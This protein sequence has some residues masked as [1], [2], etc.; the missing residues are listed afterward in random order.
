MG[1]GPQAAMITGIVKALLAQLVHYYPN[2]DDLLAQMNYRFYDIM[3]SSSL[4]I[5]ITAF[6]IVINT[7]TG[8]GIYAN[9]G[10]PNP[11]IIRTQNS[12]VEELLSKPGSALGLA[13]EMLYQI[14]R[15][16]L[17]NGDMMFMFTDGLIELMNEK[18]VQF[19]AEEL[20][21]AIQNNSNL[22]PKAFVEAILSSADAF[23]G[24]L[25]TEDDVTLLVF[26]YNQMGAD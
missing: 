14:G 1:H 21:R 8:K 18:R 11:F 12:Y 13:P 23:A 26:R 4:P 24:G 9:A 2:P 10:H 25:Y 3:S 16:T 20:Q 19:G 7:Q 22:S 15:F 6:C 17:E 5:F